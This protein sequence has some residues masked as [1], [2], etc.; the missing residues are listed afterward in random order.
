MNRCSGAKLMGLP[1]KDHGSFALDDVQEFIFLIYDLGD[2]RLDGVAGKGGGNRAD[3]ERASLR[4]FPFRG[5]QP[6]GFS[7]AEDRWHDLVFMYHPDFLFHAPILGWFFFDPWPSFDEAGQPSYFFRRV[8]FSNL[9]VRQVPAIYS[10]LYGPFSFCAAMR[11][12]PY[13]R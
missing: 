13:R 4:A 7:M 12:P 8:I 6:L 11:L 2:S 1:V 5:D 9:R 3:M 10:F